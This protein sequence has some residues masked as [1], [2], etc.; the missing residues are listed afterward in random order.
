MA[1]PIPVAKTADILGESPIWDAPNA[2]LWWIDIIGG[3]L[4]RFDH[5]AG[6]WNDVKLEQPCGSIGL[7]KAGG[8][9]AATW[10]GFGLLDPKSGRIVELANV[11]GTREAIRFND[12][13]VGRDGRFW[14]GTVQSVTGGAAFYRFDADRKVTEILGNITVSNGLTWSPDGRTM[15]LAD[16]D[17]HVIYAFDFDPAAGAISRQRVFIDYPREYGVPDGATVDTEGNLWSATFGGWHVLKIS[18]AGK[19]IEAI[20]MPVQYVTS[21]AFG[22]PDLRTM[23]V[24]SARRQMQGDELA[25][26]PLAGQLFVLNVDAQGLPDPEYL[27]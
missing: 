20:R 12:G 13:R 4:H 1:S 26:Q 25:A 8:L 11:L 27:G 23:Y 24:T 16:S 19:I 21:I 14:A 7:R 15:Y 22:G 2:C 3:V 18:P 6:T 5:A 9:V 10:P 17:A